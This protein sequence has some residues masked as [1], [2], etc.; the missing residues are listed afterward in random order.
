MSIFTELARF[1]ESHLQARTERRTR[2]LLETLPESIQKDI[3]WRWA[4]RQRGQHRSASIGF[5]GH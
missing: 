1:A 5:V 4:P 3:G 2:I